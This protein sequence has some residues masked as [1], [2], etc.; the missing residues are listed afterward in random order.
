MN[1]RSVSGAPSPI[2]LNLKNT[3][4]EALFVECS[5]RINRE[6]AVRQQHIREGRGDAGNHIL[7]QFEGLHTKSL[8]FNPGLQFSNVAIEWD[9][10]KKQVS[11][12]GSLAFFNPQRCYDASVGGA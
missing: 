1:S 7:D 6:A 12:N 5:N 10:G 9:V 8:R 4:S 11:H 3:I 2:S